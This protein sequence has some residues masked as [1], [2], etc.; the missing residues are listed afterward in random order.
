VRIQTGRFHPMN[1][2]FACGSMVLFFLF[3]QMFAHCANICVNKDGIFRPAGGGIS[4]RVNDRVRRVI[5]RSYAVGMQTGRFTRWKP[6]SP[7]AAWDVFSFVHKNVH[8][9]NIFCEHKDEFF[10]PA[11]GEISFWARDRVTPVNNAYKLIME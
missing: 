8:I 10:H 11:G 1:V 6:D 9:V 2:R 3:T 5:Y 7:A 4:C